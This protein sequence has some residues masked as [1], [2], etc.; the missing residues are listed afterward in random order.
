MSYK[1]LINKICFDYNPVKAN[2]LTLRKLNYTT[3]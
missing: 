1:E 3:L 2:I